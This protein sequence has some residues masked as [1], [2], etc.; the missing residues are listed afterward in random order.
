LVGA[1]KKK[2]NWSSIDVLSCWF[3]ALNWY[4]KKYLIR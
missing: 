2:G 4:I 3:Y 1:E